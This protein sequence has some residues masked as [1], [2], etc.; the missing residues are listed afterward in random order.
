M[1][2]S[3]IVG[4]SLSLFLFSNL[5]ARDDEDVRVFLWRA[6][7]LALAGWLAPHGFE[8]AQTAASAL[9]TSAVRMV[10]WVHC[11]ATNSRANTEPTRTTSFADS[12]ETIFVI[13]NSTN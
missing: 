7:L 8:A 9:F 3:F 2:R 10:D 13:G 5:P 6:G 1:I 11:R 4:I 12:D